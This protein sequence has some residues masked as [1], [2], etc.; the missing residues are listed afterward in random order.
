MPNKRQVLVF[1][2]FDGLHPGHL[3]FL[4]QAKKFGNYLTAV[5]ARD[6]NVLAL[7]GHCP[8][9]NERMRLRNIQKSK[10]VNQAILGYKDYRRRSRIIALVKPQIICLGYDQ[11]NIRLKNNKIKIV[12]LQPYKKEKYKSSILHAL[13]KEK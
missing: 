11:P 2:T 1:G 13:A 6:N 10:I 12:R 4:R 8:R 3:Y 5:V 9:Q 7:K